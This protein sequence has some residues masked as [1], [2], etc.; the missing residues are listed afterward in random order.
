MFECD[1]D[2]P[3]CPTMQHTMEMKELSK[4]IMGSG[5]SLSYYTQSCLKSEIADIVLK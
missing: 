5:D 2:W 3:Y 1:T 4:L